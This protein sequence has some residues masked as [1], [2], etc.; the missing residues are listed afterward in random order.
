MR[1]SWREH[2][3]ETMKSV[4]RLASMDQFPEKKCRE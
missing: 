3:S 1:E 2:D 4:S